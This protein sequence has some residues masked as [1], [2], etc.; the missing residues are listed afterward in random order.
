M[1]SP[2][3]TCG[4]SRPPYRAVRDFRL[5]RFG[6]VILP[7]ESWA[8]QSQTWRR[9]EALGFD[10][11]W[12][13][14]HLAWRSLRDRPW[15]AA[16]PT[17][18][19]AAAVTSTIRLGT[20]VASPNFRHPVPFARE[21]MTLDHISGGRFTLGIGAGG[22]GFD[23]V[24][25]RREPWS[26]RERADRFEEFVTL[27]DRLLREP[28]TTEEGRFYHAFGARMHPGCLQRPRLPFAVA[29]GG[30]RGMRLA[31]RF[32]TTWVTEGRPQP[33]GST[34]GIEAALPTLAVE[35]ERIDAA[36][37]EVGRD[38]G[39]LGRLLFVGLRVSGVTDSLEAFRDAVGRLSALGFTDLAVPWPRPAD[40]FAGDSGMLEVIAAEVQ[41]QRSARSRSAPLAAPANLPR[42]GRQIPGKARIRPAVQ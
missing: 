10:H 9:A 33:D 3:S 4:R 30:R 1:V 41:A 17:L 31:A 42:A 19:A 26:P 11:A 36:C 28:V 20:L 24:T 39:T 12:T 22:G 34:I 13:F 37:A 6:V 14:D 29:A 16:V 25:T 8:A 5:V 23:A 32:G 2:T 27:L 21:L 35:V 38:P 15:F 7:E 18:A 40:P